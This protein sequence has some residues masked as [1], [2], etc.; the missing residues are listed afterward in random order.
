MQTKQQLQKIFGQYTAEELRRLI[1]DS[2]TQKQLAKELGVSEHILRGVS[3]SL[4]I[5][6]PQGAPKKTFKYWKESQV[7]IDDGTSFEK[8]ES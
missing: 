8:G 5:V 3:K 2:P 6:R 4:G 7:T 1:L